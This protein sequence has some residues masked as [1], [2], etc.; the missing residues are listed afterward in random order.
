[1]IAALKYGRN[2]VGVEIDPDYSR[3]AARYLKK[4]SSNLFLKTE[5]IFEKLIQDN[6]DRMQVCEDQA[7]YK[8]KSAKKSLE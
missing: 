5:L 6:S 2:S 4:E 7:L 3:I 1:M 8:V